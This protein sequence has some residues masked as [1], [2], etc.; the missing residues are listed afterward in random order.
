MNIVTPNPT[1]GTFVDLVIED[2]GGAKFVKH[3]NDPGGA[4][5]WGVSLSFARYQKAR[6]DL[7]GDGDVDKADIKVLTRA[8]AVEAYQDLFWLPVKGP[9]LPA[10]LAYPTFDMAINQGVGAASR[11]LQRAV[12]ARADGGIGPMTIKAALAV[13]DKSATLAAHTA[14][15]CKRYG[16]TRNFSTF[17]G[18]WMAR[19]I[20]VHDY[21][22]G[23]VPD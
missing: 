18:G 13:H 16:E 3:P 5:K 10:Y 7:D 21:A 1:F 14:R 8:D 9:S 11:T 23:L 6:F 20:R 4:T 12:G 2:E 15:R 19:A 22:Q 17:G